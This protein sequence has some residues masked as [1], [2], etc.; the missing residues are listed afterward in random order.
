M[1]SG[2]YLVINDSVVTSETV[3]ARR[4]ANDSG[5]DYHL[6]TPEQI[7]GFFDGLDLVEPGVVSTPLWRP[8]PAPTASCRPRS[9]SC[10]AWPASPDRIHHRPPDR[11]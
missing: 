2:S 10:A 5:A 8:D 1:P 11:I 3:D 9:T 6:R 7:E 4:A